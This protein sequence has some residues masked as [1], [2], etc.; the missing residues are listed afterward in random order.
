MMCAMRFHHELTYAAPPD[1]V[2]AMLADPAFREQVARE[3]GVLSVEVT[4][5]PHDDG[6][7]LVSDQVQ[8]TAGLPAIARRIAG[9]S[10]RAVITE[11]W[12][13]AAGGSIEITAPGKP[14]RATGTITLEPEVNGTREVVDLDVKVKVPL[15]GGK[16]EKLMVD[17]IE[18]GYE[19]EHQVG[20][21][22]LAG[23]ER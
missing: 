2:F 10:T 21:A 23:E 11:E 18:E 7:S 19:V 22:W 5:T 8:N 1:V 14:T 13:S 9:D 16:L 6:F 17:T 15:L 4:L 20:T 3:Q 12:T